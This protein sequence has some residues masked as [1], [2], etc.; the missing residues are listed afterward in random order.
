MEDYIIRRANFSDMP[1]IAALL[2]TSGLPVVRVHDAKY[3]LVA[4]DGQIIGVIGAIYDTSQALLRSFAV[5]PYK[6]ARGIGGKLVERMLI[7]LKMNKL[8][9]V[10]LI[11]DTA[12]DYFRHMGFQE[13]QREVVPTGLLTESGLDKACP[14]SSRCMKYILE[15]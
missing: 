3:F 15:A 2:T 13:I 4:D 1:E 6:R 10:Y 12:A 11:T 14:C 5:S 9:E 8:Q 7:E